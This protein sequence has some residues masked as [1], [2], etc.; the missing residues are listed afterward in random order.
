MAVSAGNLHIETSYKRI[1]QNVIIAS[2]EGIYIE[3]ERLRS[4]IIVEARAEKGGKIKSYRSINGYSGTWSC[5]DEINGEEYGKRCALY[6]KE[7]LE[8]ISCP[9]GK[10]PV[11]LG[12]GMG[13]TLLHEAC[14]HSLE[15]TYVVGGNSEFSGKLEEKIASDI[16][17]VVDDGTFAGGWGTEKYD[18]E[19]TK[20]RK[21]ILIEK[22]ILKSYLVDRLNS[23]VLKLPVT[24]NG[25]REGYMYTP[26]SRM[27]NTYIMPGRE[28]KEEIIGS[29][30]YGIYA[31]EIGDGSVDPLSGGFEFNITRG[32]IIKNGKVDRAVD[33]ATIIGTGSEVLRKIDRVGNKLEMGQ[34]MC[35]ST[36]GT[37]PVGLGQPIIRVQDMMVKGN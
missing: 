31:V 30:D 13:G 21:N 19:G 14:G 9:S 28:N 25:R 36:S 29:T 22:G 3:D 12:G 27:T 23:E 26:T 33:G 20:S 34:C 5:L 1:K 18:D 15:A 8:A 11:V 37:L 24:G 7:K 32:Y 16:I 4:R 35:G 17:T 6:A 2:S 10:F